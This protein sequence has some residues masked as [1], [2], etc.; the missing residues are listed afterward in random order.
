LL[1]TELRDF[2]KRG[3]I[4]IDRRRRAGIGRGVIGC[5]QMSSNLQKLDRRA[6]SIKEAAQTC[7]LSRATLY[8]LIEQNKL[9]TLKIGSRRLVTVA[10]IDAL[11]NGGAQ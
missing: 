3:D 8:R 5:G 2:A 6:L 9:A 4:W 1:D 10:A 11:L 7:G